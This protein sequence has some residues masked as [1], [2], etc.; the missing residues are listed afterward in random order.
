MAKLEVTRKLRIHIS[1]NGRG[2]NGVNPPWLGFYY[3]YWIP[4]F[5]FMR[6]AAGW[7]A[8]IAWLCFHSS[9]YKDR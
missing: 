1:V 6:W 4:R 8:D 2:D 7:Y 3:G 5:Q 9:V